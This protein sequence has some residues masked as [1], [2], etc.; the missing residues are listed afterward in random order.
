MPDLPSQTRIDLDRIASCGVVPVIRIERP[1]DAPDLARALAGA[2]LTCL[3]ITFRTGAAAEAIAAV[4]ATQPDVLVGAGT[5]LSMAQLDQASEAGA[6][7]I[8]S[9]GF[10]P[11]VVQAC[12]ERG[13]PVLPGVLTPSEILAA[14]DLGLTQLKLFPAASAGGPAYLRTLAGPFPDVRFM[15]TGGI[16]AD[17]LEAYLRVPAVFA[18]GGSWMVQPGLLAAR[19]WDEVARL[20][21][22]AVAVVRAVRSSAV[23]R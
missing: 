1:D 6:S 2:G 16:G 9:P 11:D 12:I 14:L 10:Q 21:A 4:R 23:P 8:V 7:F 18:V 17:D 13:T 3:E 15:P 20:A 22:E 5:V 19:E